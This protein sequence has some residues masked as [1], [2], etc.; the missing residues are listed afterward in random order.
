MTSEP[1]AGT[2]GQV[3][4]PVEPIASKRYALAVLALA[5]QHSD[6]PAWQNALR[7][8]AEFMGDP[9]VKRVLEN[10]R[11]GQ[12]PKQRLISAAL[13]DLP[14]LQLNFA[15]LLVRKDRTGLAGEIVGQFDR[16]LEEEQGVTRARATTAVPLSDAERD[17]LD[18]QAPGA[19]RP[20]RDPGN[21]GRPGP[22]GRRRRPDRRPP[23]RCQHPRKAHG[24]AGEARRQLCRSAALVNLRN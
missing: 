1:N 8:I 18:G 23:R 17:A 21:R 24:A 22:A 7:Q 11:V 5:Q 16:L 9:E 10:S 19:D 15:R 3:E 20:G 4:A 6:A 13:N 14:V 12:E 2:T